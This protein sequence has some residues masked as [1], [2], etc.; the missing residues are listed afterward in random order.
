MAGLSRRELSD[1]SGVSAEAI[2]RIERN[3]ADPHSED[4]PEAGTVTQRHQRT[5]ILRKTTLTDRRRKE[6]DG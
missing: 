5:A 1:R 2:Q 3:G 6:P 4:S